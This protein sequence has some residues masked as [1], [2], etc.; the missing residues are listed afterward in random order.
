MQKLAI[1]TGGSKGLGKSLVE[2][3]C[4]RGYQVISI[5]RSSSDYHHPNLRLQI[6][7]DLSDIENIETSLQDK[8]KEVFSNDF[9]KVTLINNAARLGQIGKVIDYTATDFNKAVQ[10]NFTSPI[11]LSNLIIKLLENKDTALSIL[12]VSSGA[13][14]RAIY[15]WGMYCSTKAGLDAISKVMAEESNGI[16][17]KIAII[18]PGIM[19][20]EMQGAIR[21]SAQEDFPLVENFQQYQ[22]D[23]LLVP[24]ATIAHLIAEMDE[25]NDYE[26]GETVRIEERFDA[27]RFRK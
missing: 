25:K 7:F 23:N 12:N 16:G 3:Y 27:P 1:I 19:D 24:P 14:N 6:E 17:Y 5:A 20:T 9:D 11:L 21:N 13:A 2:E 26:N 15:G 8:L 22:K 4:E 10:L 18:N